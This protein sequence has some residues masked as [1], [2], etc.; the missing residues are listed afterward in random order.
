MHHA[1][2]FRHAE[3]YARS[4]D[5]AFGAHHLAI[6]LLVHLPI[7]GVIEGASGKNAYKAEAAST[8]MISLHP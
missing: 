5:L 6:T 4:D 8:C 1:M 7:S 3:M 2:R